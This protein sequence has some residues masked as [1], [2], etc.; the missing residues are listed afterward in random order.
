[1]NWSIVACEGSDGRLL[2]PLISITRSQLQVPDVYIL[3]LVRG[4][5]DPV[6]EEHRPH[7]HG[8][9]ELSNGHALIKIPENC[10][11]VPTAR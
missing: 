5:D 1:M 6:I 7:I 9:F 8:V 3:E 2:P 10:S 4:D 11:L